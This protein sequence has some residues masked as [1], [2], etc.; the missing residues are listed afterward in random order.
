MQAIAKVE[1]PVKVKLPAK[2]S[3]WKTEHL[4]DGAVG[5]WRSNFITTFAA[6]IGTKHSPWDIK[7]TESLMAMQECWDHVY[8]ST[9]AAHHRIVG[10]HDIVFYLV[11]I[12]TQVK[13]RL[14]GSYR[15]IND[16]R[17]YE[18]T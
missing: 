1:S 11:S 16:G 14:T 15:V 13:Y 5:K 2:M 12:L 3:E 6:Y 17:S 9:I 10:T 4:P 8:Q 18:T 7:D